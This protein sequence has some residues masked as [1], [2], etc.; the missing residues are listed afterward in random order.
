QEG[1]MIVQLFARIAIRNEEGRYLVIHNIKEDVVFDKGFRRNRWE[2]PGGK[3][4]EG[5]TAAAAAI[6]EAQ[7]ETGIVVDKAKYVS[8]VVI[9][10]DGSEWIGD[11]YFA[12][13]WHG[14]ASIKE[15]H[16]FD[17]LRWVTPEEL[18]KLSQVPA[19]SIDI[20]R[21]CERDYCNEVYCDL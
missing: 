7:E 4:D 19:L 2:I 17:D 9:S 18:S 16:K 10:I 11:F 6:R 12:E 15:P 20:V 5:E 21:T 14:E 13:E 1:S 8:R 3:I